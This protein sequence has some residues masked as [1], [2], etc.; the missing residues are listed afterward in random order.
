MRHSLTVVFKEVKNA[1]A[2]RINRCLLYQLKINRILTHRRTFSALA[3]TPAGGLTSSFQN[4]AATAASAGNVAWS[5][6]RK[7]AMSK[8]LAPS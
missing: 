1:C 2:W 5:C 3:Q 8:G 7:L 6:S 4:T